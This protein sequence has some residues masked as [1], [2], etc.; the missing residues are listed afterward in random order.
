MYNLG[1]ACSNVLKKS[2]LWTTE[3]LGGT[4]F[5]PRHDTII[6]LLLYSNMLVASNLKRAYL[7]RNQLSWWD[8]T[9]LFCLCA[10]FSYSL[11][12]KGE[13]Q[14]S[15]LFFAL[16]WV[17]TSNQ[18]LYL[19]ASVYVTGCLSAQKLQRDSK[20]TGCNIPVGVD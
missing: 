9:L 3:P 18:K 2:C 15:F 6:C 8:K 11:C 17:L 4:S 16:H 19:K 1:F 13:R 10:V 12:P 20:H 5:I 14:S 7:K